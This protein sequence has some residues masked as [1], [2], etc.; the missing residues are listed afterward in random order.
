MVESHF[1]RVNWTNTHEMVRISPGSHGCAGI[2][3][4]SKNIQT[5][6]AAEL[7]REDGCGH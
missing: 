2:R 3:H 5:A 4:A 1:E 6:F 7:R